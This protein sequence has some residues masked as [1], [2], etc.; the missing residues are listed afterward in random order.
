[1]RI[2]ELAIVLGIFLFVCF[3][4]YVMNLALTPTI[5]RLL[6]RSTGQFPCQIEPVMPTPLPADVGSNTVN[7]YDIHDYLI[8][9]TDNQIRVNPEINGHFIEADL[10][11]T[12]RHW[13]VY[14][15]HESI[16]YSDQD[17]A[18][19]AI[20]NSLNRWYAES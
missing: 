17:T 9:V 8:V 11:Q 18:I 20:H 5:D 12:N 3:T 2:R 14:R 19:N 13:I 16:E 10:D 6:G 15:D 1:M 7:L 4:G